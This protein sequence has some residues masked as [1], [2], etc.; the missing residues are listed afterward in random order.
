MEEV[1]KLEKKDSFVITYFYQIE[2]YKAIEEFYNNLASLDAYE[3]VIRYDYFENLSAERRQHYTEVTY[4]NGNGE[5][6]FYIS[7]TNRVRKKAEEHKDEKLPLMDIKYTLTD[8]QMTPINSS[9]DA[10]DY[11]IKLFNEDTLEYQEEVVLLA[12]I[13]NRTV[14]YFKLSKG[15]TMST[16]I[17]PKQLF[18]RLLTAGATSFIVAHNHPSGKLRPSDADKAITDK[19]LKGSKALDLQML[20]HV[21]VTRESYFS[22]IDEGLI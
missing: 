15:G 10:Y 21:I 20:D 7:H 2:H 14:G 4:R 18:S 5:T 16:I 11:M 9:Q 3:E 22:F 12:M 19:L 8:M 17:D 1:S 13:N 6:Y